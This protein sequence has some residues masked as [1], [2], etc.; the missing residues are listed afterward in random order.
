[1]LIIPLLISVLK[2]LLPFITEPLPR[3]GQW[4]KDSPHLLRGCAQRTGQICLWNSLLCVSHPAIIFIQS[5]PWVKSK[6]VCWNSPVTIFWFSCGTYIF[7]FFPWELF[8]MIKALLSWPLLLKCPTVTS[9]VLNPTSLCGP[10]DHLF[11]TNPFNGCE[12]SN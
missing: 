9:A 6:P 2:H 8:M 10:Q 12:L 5:Q 4:E 3:C 7:P 11:K 1:M